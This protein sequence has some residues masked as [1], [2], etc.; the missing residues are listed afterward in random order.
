M[1]KINLQMLT[2]LAIVAALYVALTLAL[3]PLSYGAI[4]FRVSEALMLL[5]IY[6]PIY[7]ISLTLGC[8]VANIASSLG[9]VDILF[10]TLATLIS[11]LCMMKV[12][13]VFVSSLFPS[14]V[15]GIVIGLE[16]YFLW[17]VP[18]WLGMIQVFAGEFVV[19]TLIGIPLFK[20]F[21]KNEAFMKQLEIQPLMENQSKLSSFLDGY[22]SL[23]LALV[24]V[25]ILLFFNLGL[26]TISVD[27][28]TNRYTLYIY[29]TK[30]YDLNNAYPILFGVLVLPVI[31]VVLTKFTKK[32]IAFISVIIISI[33]GIVLLGYAI[34]LSLQNIEWYYCSYFLVFIAMI[35]LA[36]F[37]FKK[38]QSIKQELNN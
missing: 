20:S 25:S 26:Y 11:C 22:T 31:A 1:K 17:E 12:K 4:Q 32:I 9:P 27:D 30:G 18:L 37:K 28:I 29:A 16:L 10:G 36:S 8:L 15:N 5:V 33:I 19:C 34:S 14:I 6:N 35:I 7:S 38:E 21:E 3:Q 2:K 24:I 23:M 13:N